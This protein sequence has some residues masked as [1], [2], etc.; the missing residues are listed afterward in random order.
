[1][2][3]RIALKSLWLAR[4][5]NLSALVGLVI[6]VGAIVAMLALTLTVRREA[7][8]Q[9]DRSGRNVIAIRPADAPPPAA[10]RKPPK[11]DLDLV[12]GLA[13][14]VASLENA[15]PVIATRAVFSADGRAFEADVLGV[16]AAFFDLNTLPI[17][18]GRALSDLDRFQPF[19]V[20]G[21][22]QAIAIARGGDTDALVGKQIVIEQR[23]F[24]VIGVAAAAEAINLH[25]GDLNKAILLPAT[26][27]SR[28]LFPAEVGV[29]YAR[30]DGA[31]R[32]LEIAAEVRAY[33]QQRGGV[34][35]HVTSAEQLVAEMERQL[36]IFALFLGAIGALALLLGG[37]GML[38]SLLLAVAERR[39]E[40][41]LRRA[42]GALRSDIQAQFLFEALTLCTIGGVVGV[43]VGA[44]AS[45]TISRSAGWTPA[46][47]VVVVVAGLAVA[48]IVGAGAGFVPA[49]Q[50][51]R[52]DPSSALKSEG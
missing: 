10:L 8:R 24:T 5:R 38:N 32:P 28:V 30:I 6:G 42:V 40:I 37:A 43:L 20:L 29:V 4:R 25:A 3:F 21:R 16:T 46:L 18:S 31:A 50:A 1:M 33:F 39:V 26:T 14:S 27:A 51:A 9:F 15:A 47:P 36:R 52:L 23:V 49:W 41:G 44:I 48:L 7:L 19:V 22:D 2:N 12:D 45:G 13:G 34:A 17:A 35:V 11:L